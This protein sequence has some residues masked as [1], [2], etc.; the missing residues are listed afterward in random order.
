MFCRCRNYKTTTLLKRQGDP[1]KRNR[2]PLK[3]D[4][5]KKSKRSIKVGVLIRFH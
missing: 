3:K 5:K 4:I 2:A 1:H